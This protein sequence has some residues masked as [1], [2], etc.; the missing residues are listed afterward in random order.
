MKT[1]IVVVRGGGEHDESA[2]LSLRVILFV[3]MC[4]TLKSYNV[5]GLPPP[6]V[7]PSQGRSAALALVSRPVLLLRSVRA[8]ALSA[9]E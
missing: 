8:R 4:C 6:G 2:W 1:L 7:L 5:L 9:S 3:H